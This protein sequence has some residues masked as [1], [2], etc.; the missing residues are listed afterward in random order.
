VATLDEKQREFL[1]NPYYA[2]VSTVR[3]DGSVH[4][5]VVWVDVDDE[6]L[7]FNTSIDRAKE[8]HLR[9]NQNVSIIV[10]DPANP[11]K[12][13]SVSGTAELRTESGDADIDHLS[14]KYLGKDYPYRQPGEVRVTVRVPSEK[15]EALGLDG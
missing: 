6:G 14:N 15:V 10:V 2:V 1:A 3:D 11:Y 9:K 12:W 4:N 8:R 7:W 13:V 5:T